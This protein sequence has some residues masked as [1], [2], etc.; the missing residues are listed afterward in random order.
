M[1]VAYVF[2]TKEGSNICFPHVQKA[3]K[4]NKKF[5]WEFYRKDYV[6]STY[7]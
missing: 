5:F 2:M 6:N 1:F 4:V 3:V 7:G